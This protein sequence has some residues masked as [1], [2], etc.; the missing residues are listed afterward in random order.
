MS[1][2]IPALI[3]NLMSVCA[4]WA[5]PNNA[6]HIAADQVD[7]LIAYPEVDLDFWILRQE[8]RKRRDKDV[9]CQRRS[10]IDTQMTFRLA[11]CGAELAVNVRQFLYNTN[12]LLVVSLALGRHRYAPGRALQKLGANERFERL[13]QFGD[14]CLGHLQRICSS[15]KAPCLYNTREFANCE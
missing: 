11:M 5:A 6:I 9:P 14:R 3:S 12:G 15:C 1:A 2:S 7:M 13:H 4:E 8:V 10:N